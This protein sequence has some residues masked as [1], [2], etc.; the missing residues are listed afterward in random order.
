MVEVVA[1]WMAGSDRVP[2]AEISSEPWSVMTNVFPARAKW[3]ALW[4]AGS[5]APKEAL[6]RA[7]TFK[8][9]PLPEINENSFTLTRTGIWGDNG[10]RS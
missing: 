3:R 4:S 9:A 7:D 5:R 1:E 2:P 6:D 10:S 8:D